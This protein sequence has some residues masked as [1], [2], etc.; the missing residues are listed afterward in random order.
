MSCMAAHSAACCRSLPLPAA[1]PLVRSN[2]LL[3]PKEHRD[4]K[5]LYYACR[6]CPFEQEA[7]SPCVYVNAIKQS[8]TS[9]QHT[10]ERRG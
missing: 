7:N 6:N 4:E 10:S 2:N 1:L 5:K 8:L 9:E 3:Y